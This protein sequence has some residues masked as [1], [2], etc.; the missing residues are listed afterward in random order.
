MTGSVPPV[1]M[2]TRDPDLVS[3]FSPLLGHS[4]EL[5]VLDRYTDFQRE[6]SRRGA[7]VVLLDV[8]VDRQTPEPELLLRE[9]PDH[10]FIAL[11][12]PRSAPMRTA[13]VASMFAA[14]DM[15]TPPRHLERTIVLAQQHLDLRVENQQ[16]R[17]QARLQAALPPPAPALPSSP[18]SLLSTRDL[19]RLLRVL[20]DP[21][22]LQTH[23]LEEVISCLHLS[24]AGL[25]L[26]E[27]SGEFFSVQGGNTLIPGTE[28][29]RFHET[30]PFI[31][32]LERNAHTVSRQTL[33]AIAPNPGEHLML[34]RVLDQLGAEILVP[35]RGRRGM[36]GAFFCGRPL[37]GLPPEQEQTDQILLAADLISVSVERS[38]LHQ[39][40]QLQRSR[41]EA[42]LNELPVGVVFANR[43]GKIQWC[44]P[45]VGR[46]LG[47]PEGTRPPRVLG[48]LGEAVTRAAQ[49]L[50]PGMEVTDPVTERPIRIVAV[51][52]QPD[53]VLITLEDRRQEYALKA[54]QERV[55]RAAFWT[56]LAAS[57]S[58]EVRNP[59]VAINTFAQ[60]LPE[61]YQDH[62]FREE[63][64]SM[65][66]REVEKLGGMIDQINAFAHPPELNIQPLDVRPLLQQAAE[67]ARDMSGPNVFERLTPSLPHVLADGAALSAALDHLLKNA[68][69]AAAGPG[70]EIMI[71]ASEGRDVDGNHVVAIEIHDNGPGVPDDILED[72][73]SPFTTTKA[74]G[75]GLGLAIAHRTLQDQGGALALTTSPRGTSVTL[76][77]PVH[78]E[79]ST[80]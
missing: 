49:E 34:Q 55:E 22:S 57:M 64:S 14:E 32:W 16:L 35:L 41:A 61:R 59:L 53:G 67:R 1:L 10:L 43:E 25:I 76:I 37:S 13:A 5:V 17:E 72:P 6:A 66:G 19:I 58:H 80:P 27:G 65:V 26:Q 51:N 3:R 39:E 20:D 77:L 46:I 28:N 74:K 63:F 2:F 45:A 7:C 70:G 15:H 44:S 11:G 38:L 21:D 79:E 62:E 50:S 36:L 24:R 33:S 12:I 60:L 75:L 68:A 4:R 54:E 31:L 8:R 29:T 47:I 56:R 71:H 78:R 9:F 18:D 42:L 52:V 73:Y 40:V 48:D 30:D 69:E 23:L